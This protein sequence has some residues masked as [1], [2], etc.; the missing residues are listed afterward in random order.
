V[1][2]A[3]GP[4]TG[5]ESMEKRQS[6]HDRPAQSTYHYDTYKTSVNWPAKID[7]KANSCRPVGKFTRNPVYGRQEVIWPSRCNA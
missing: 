2:N 3:A 4:D 1:V 5:D 6:T 7:E